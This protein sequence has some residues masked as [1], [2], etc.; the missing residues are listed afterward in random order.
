MA[1]YFVELP[2]ET[3]QSELADNAIDHLTSAYPNWVPHEGN[4]E[5]VQIEAI[6]PMAQNAAEVAARVPSTI[7]REFGTDLLGVQYGF[8]APARASTNWTLSD[9]DGHT[10]PADTQVAIEG[11]AFVVDADEVVPVGQT[12]V[13]DVGVTAVDDGAVQNGLSGTAELISALDWVDL[14][15][16]VGTSVGGSDPEDDSDYQN[17]LSEILTLTA[18]RP[19]TPD[20]FAVMAR[21][22]PGVTVGRSTAIDGYN[23]ANN[24]YNNEKCVAVYVTDETGGALSATEMQAIDDFLESHREVNFIVTVN[25][26]KYDTLHIVTHVQGYSGYD[27][28]DLETRIEQA[29]I[30]YLANY[31]IPQTSDVTAASWVSDR[32]VRKNKLIDLIGNVPGVDYVLDVTISGTLGTALPNGDWQMPGPVALPNPA[33]TADATV[34][35]P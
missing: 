29:I 26:P 30:D 21:Y 16:V 27:Q 12:T 33:S 24:T 23:P 18:P 22:T 34:T 9:A 11:Y 14:V 19:I 35:L 2:V 3:D 13:S 10:I 5:V 15:T 17:R 28:A 20:D 7:F 25:A 31:G 1:S 32:V 6:S 4:L 8:G